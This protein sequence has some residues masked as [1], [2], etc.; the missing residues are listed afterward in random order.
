[1]KTYEV[2]KDDIG[3]PRR[4]QGAAVMA[5]NLA[6]GLGGTSPDLYMAGSS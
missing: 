6:A 3:K 2:S 1:M 5:F 4:W